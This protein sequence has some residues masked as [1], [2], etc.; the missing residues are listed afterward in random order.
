MLKNCK[1][2]ETFGANFRSEHIQPRR[3][4]ATFAD[5]KES[6]VATSYWYQAKNVEF[7]L[8]YIHGFSP[9]SY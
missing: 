3:L 9:P 4:F 2:R 8:L 6:M 5:E 1:K 7:F